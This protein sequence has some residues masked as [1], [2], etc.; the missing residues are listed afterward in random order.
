MK[1][2]ASFERFTS[3]HV[4]FPFA[5]RIARRY[6]SGAREFSQSETS[7]QASARMIFRPAIQGF[8]QALSDS[9]AA[10][11]FGAACFENI[12]MVT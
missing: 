7:A 8:E 6:A 2:A 4:Q 12:P 11:G 1:P 5:D 9:G 10:A 3:V